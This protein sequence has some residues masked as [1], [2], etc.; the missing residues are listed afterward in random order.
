MEDLLEGEDEDFDRDDKVIITHRDL[1]FAL[2]C[3]FTVRCQAKQNI[4]ECS[5]M[6]IA[7]KISLTMFH[8]QYLPFNYIKKEKKP[9]TL[10]SDQM[11]VTYHFYA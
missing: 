7:L 8:F 3:R 9:L 2:W 10:Y 1:Q 5:E 4:S 11:K 6:Q